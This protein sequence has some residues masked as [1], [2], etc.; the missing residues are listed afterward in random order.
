MAQFTSM[1]DQAARG[2]LRQPAD[3]ALQSLYEGLLSAGTRTQGSMVMEMIGFQDTKNRV[4]P[5][6]RLYQSIFNRKPDSAGLDFW[7]SEYRK[8]PTGQDSLASMAASWFGTSEYKNTYPASLSNQQFVEK[9]YQNVF[10]RVPD[11]AG[12][13]YWTQQLDSGSYSRV[14]VII[15]FSES[16]ENQARTNGPIANLLNYAG[17]GDPRAYQGPLL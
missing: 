11:S 13:A 5:V 1:I 17:W 10:G 12:V 6:V 8:Y 15:F 4:F 7:V 3:A 2:V 16:A 14:G 9:V